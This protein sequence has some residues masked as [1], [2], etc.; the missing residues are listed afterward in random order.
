M[1]QNFI[2]WVQDVGPE[3]V[4]SPREVWIYCFKV[5]ITTIN[6]ILRLFIGVRFYYKISTLGFLPVL[7]YYQRPVTGTSALI[8]LKLFFKVLSQEFL[9]V[10]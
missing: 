6:F 8:F 10:S 2:K 9:P 4:Q 3:L 7:Y 1:W 5:I